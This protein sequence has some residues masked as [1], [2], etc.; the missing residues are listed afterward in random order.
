MGNRETRGPAL[1]WPAGGPSPFC[2]S[3]SSA[4]KGQ[5]WDQMLSANLPALR[6][7]DAVK[8]SPTSGPLVLPVG[9]A[10]WPPPPCQMPTTSA[11]LSR[12]LVAVQLDT[13][14][15]EENSQVNPWPWPCFCSPATQTSPAKH[16]LLKR[17]ARMDCSLDS[18]TEDPWVRISDCIKNLFSP[19]MSENHG[20]LPLQPN[21]S[22]GEEDGPRGHPDGTPLKLDSPNGAP[23]LYKPAD[24][25]TVKKG[26]PV[27][28]KPAWFRQSLKGLRGRAPD[29]RRLPDAA[30]GAQAAPAP[31]ERPG[32]PARAA[33]SIRQR[34][35]SFETFGSP[36]PPDRGLQRLSLHSSSGEA[37]KPPE[38][39][40]A[41]WVSGPG[42]R[43]APP[44]AEQTQPE[45]ERLPPASPAASEAGDPTGSGSPAPV[46]QPSQK[47]LLADPDPLSRLPSTPPEGSRV[48]V[49]KMPSQRARSFPLSR[50]QSCEMQP[51]DEKTSKLYSISSQVS[52]AVMKSLLCLPSSFSCGQT[53]C[54]PKEAASPTSPSGEDP[55][56]SSSAETLASDTGFSLK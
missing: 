48:T 21:V 49:V 55:A 39:Q 34:I 40:E 32:V 14:T 38:R 42:R 23:K 11:D 17:Q 28:P 37:A 20:H 18:T 45:Q 33:S 12:V 50:T 15:W 46:R 30:S 25:S 5:T 8:L 52:S 16:P 56:A 6:R 7:W 3:D 19:I 9:P 36:Q 27:A 13:R 24:G 35:S 29:P 2:M 31:R 4:V 26:P 1:S 44:T 43:G 47:A 10:Q 41:G 53:A 22:L 54:L 51:F